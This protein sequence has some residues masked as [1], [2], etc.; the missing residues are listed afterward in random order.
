MFRPCLLQP[1]SR[2]PGVENAPFSAIDIGECP[3]G[4]GTQLAGAK[5][6]APTS[7]PCSAT[8]LGGD[9]DGSGTAGF[10]PC[11]DEE[12]NAAVRQ[13]KASKAQ[14]V[15]M[16]KRSG[17]RINV[18]PAFSKQERR[19]SKSSLKRHC[20]RGVE[21]KRRRKLRSSIVLFSARAIGREAREKARHFTGISVISRETQSAGTSLPRRSPENKNKGKHGQRGNTDPE[22]YALK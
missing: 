2:N 7:A 5:R 10:F 8:V 17:S 3:P 11:C 6:T 21:N 19:A 20:T 15:R 1:Q 12:A 18:L 14:M 9:G 16:N 22:D 4:T 13:M